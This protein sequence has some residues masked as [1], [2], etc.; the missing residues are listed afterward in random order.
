MKRKY[1]LKGFST[2][3]DAQKRNHE[4]ALNHGIKPDSTTKYMFS[5]HCLQREEWGLEIL[6]DNL[7]LLD[8]SEKTPERLREI[9]NRPFV[10][11]YLPM[12]F[13]YLES[14]WVD[15]FFKSGS[16]RLSSFKKFHKHEDEQRGDK[17]EGSNII[18]GLRGG[19]QFFAVTG[20]GQDAFVL[21]TSLTY[22]EKMYEDFDVDACFVI[23]KPHEFINVII[24]KI[25]EF[26]GLNH[27]P[28]LY[29]PDK[30]ITRQSPGFDLESPKSDD[31]SNT[32]DMGE[33]F[34]VINQAGG[35][36]VLFL[37]TNGYSQQ[38]EYRMLWHTYL[39]PMPEHIDLIVPEAI[40]YCRKIEKNGG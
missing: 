40:Q 27:G 18:V 15:E 23:E 13:R 21:S 19:G 33:M 6:E 5:A 31:D 17:N 34:N 20:H 10:N 36:D 11:A 38:H 30:I 12:V 9:P 35:L 39:D 37:K 8:E 7:N 32:N 22:N 16:L 26:R 28:C 24:K 1:I 14:K 4:F 25:P 2:R 3:E 29:Q